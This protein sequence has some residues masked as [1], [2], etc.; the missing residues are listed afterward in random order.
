METVVRRMRCHYCDR[1][2]SFAPELGGVQVG[3]CDAHFREQFEDLAES[4]ALASLRQ[5]L[6]IDRPD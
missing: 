5:E 4:E 3:L 1:T 2:A 6:D